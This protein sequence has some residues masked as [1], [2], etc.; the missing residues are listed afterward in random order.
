MNGQ[1]MIYK[2]LK[3]LNDEFSFPGDSINLNLGWYFKA[4]LLDAPHA[5]ACEDIE[6]V[7]SELDVDARKISF[8]W[9]IKGR[10]NSPADEQFYPNIVG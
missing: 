2:Q 9:R 6:H 5:L 3:A 8:S 10:H 4:L 7:P 1:M